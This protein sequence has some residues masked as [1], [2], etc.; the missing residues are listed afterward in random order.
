MDATQKRIE[1][2]EPELVELRRHFHMYPE[3]GF[4]EFETAKKVESYLQAIGLETFRCAGTGV[5]A[6]IDSGRPGP[7]LMLRADMDALPITEENDV[8]YQSQK[9]GNMHACGHDA[10]MAMLL[11]AAKV[12]VENRFAFKGTIKLVFQPNEEIA[13]AVKMIEEGVM[14]NPKVDAAM[15]IHIW[16]LISS[17]RVSI[18]P[19][20][21]MGG[22]DVFK[23]K[24]NG[25][26]GHTGYPHKAID[27][28]I[29]AANVIQSVQSIQTRQNNVQNPV[30][31][32]FGKVNGGTKANIIPEQVALEGTIRFLHAAPQDSDQNPTRKFIRMCEQ[33]CD[34]YQCSCEINIEHENIPLIND[35]R[36]VALAKSAAAEV[37]GGNDMIDHARYI[38]GEDFSEFLTMV[39]GV[40]TFLGCADP[41]LKTDIAHHNPKF[42][43]DEGV[44]KK[45]VELHVK[46]ALTYLN[47]EM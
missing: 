21:V 38:A 4:E 41:D 5:V 10:H 6:L 19:G 26:G 45:G 23:M 29:A 40:F 44:L 8:S 13:G 16:S 36:M 3:L 39:P 14:D 18:T 33:L 42:N 28:V 32:M 7:C 22:L 11:V 37:M 9:K 35:E 17:G 12:L 47:R 34:T 27:P 30:I 46:S 31:I 15:A 25:K 1:Q 20:V 43:I 2:L 24:I